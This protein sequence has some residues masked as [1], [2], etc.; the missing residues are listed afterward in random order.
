MKCLIKS[1]N[2][3]KNNTIL[4]QYKFL[5]FFRSSRSS[6]FSDLHNPSIHRKQLSVSLKLKLLDFFQIIKIGELVNLKWQQTH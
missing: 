6:I 5:I 1:E 4:S 3:N 2:I